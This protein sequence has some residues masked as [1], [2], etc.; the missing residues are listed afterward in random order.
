MLALTCF[1]LQ[2]N[3]KWLSVKG[4]A[5]GCMKRQFPSIAPD[6]TKLYDGFLN[7][8]YVVS[9]DESVPAGAFNCHNKCA[10]VS[11][12]VHHAALQPEKK[13]HVETVNSMSLLLP[14]EK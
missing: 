6:D 7:G 3:L 9:C 1:Y 12:F 4:F 10:W 13:A 8:Y 11:V 2:L 14:G 5:V